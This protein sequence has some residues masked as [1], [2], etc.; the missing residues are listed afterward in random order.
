MMGT[1]SCGRSARPNTRQRPIGWTASQSARRGPLATYPGAEIGARHRAPRGG[2]PN[3]GG[4]ANSSESNCSASRSS[5]PVGSGGGLSR[6]L[7][8][9]GLGV[10]AGALQLPFGVF[11]GAA[12]ALAAGGARIL[13]ASHGGRVSSRGF[14]ACRQ[15]IA[16]GSLFIATN[17]AVPL[18]STEKSPAGRCAR[19]ALPQEGRCEATPKRRGQEPRRPQLVGAACFSSKLARR[20]MAPSTCFCAIGRSF[21]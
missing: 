6:R 3:A 14:S 18:G 13:R 1:L 15:Q 10:L 19:F 11:L 9:G 7:R 5:R 12:F 16:N 17:R 8:L 21:S 4:Q 2:C 20:G